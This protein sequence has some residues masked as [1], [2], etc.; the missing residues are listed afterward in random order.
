MKK[1]FA[2]IPHDVRETLFSLTIAVALICGSLFMLSTYIGNITEAQDS[3]EV[4]A[5]PPIEESTE[6][7]AP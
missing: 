2:R 6:S 3:L 7:S 5:P 1:F 4:I